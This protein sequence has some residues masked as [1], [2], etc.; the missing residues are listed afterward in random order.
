MDIRTL[1]GQFNSD[2]I[3]D[4]EK[5]RPILRDFSTD[6]LISLEDHRIYLENL[7]GFRGALVRVQKLNGDDFI[8]ILN[9]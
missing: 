5:L 6:D 9:P 3:S 4:L 8:N 7:R 2:S 1:I